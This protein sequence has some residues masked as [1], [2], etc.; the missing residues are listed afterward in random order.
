M[1]LSLAVSEADSACALDNKRSLTDDPSA[2]ESA[3]LLPHRETQPAPVG[4]PGPA[5][6]QPQTPPNGCVPAETPPPPLN[7]HP[8]N[9][10]VSNG[11]TP[12]CSPP[13]SRAPHPA[14]CNCHAHPGRR[15][16]LSSAPSGKS[17]H[18][19]KSTAAQIQQAAGDDR[20]VHCV[21]ACLFCELPSL[22][23]ALL[24]CLACGRG[25]G[26]GGCCGGGASGGGGGED[27]CSTGVDCGILEDCCQSSDCLEIC[28]ECCSICFP[29]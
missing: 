18:S 4:V 8:H 24:L 7:G 12:I 23:S 3:Q 22:C 6:P 21:L 13:P 19:L 9:G 27:V 2:N 25:C 10:S 20:C 11:T 5:L 28:F 26:G 1:P 16:R 29:A 14:Q 17:Q 15:P